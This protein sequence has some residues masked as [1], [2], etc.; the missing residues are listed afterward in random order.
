MTTVPHLARAMQTVLTTQ[1]R[2][3]YGQA[4]GALDRGVSG[5]QAAPHG[6]LLTVRRKTTTRHITAGDPMPVRRLK[7]DDALYRGQTLP[8]SVSVLS[9]SLSGMVS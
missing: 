2:G 9:G 6:L 4:P 7:P 3:R 5:A 1:A 8:G